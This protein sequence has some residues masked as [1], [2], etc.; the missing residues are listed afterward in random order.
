MRAYCQPSDL[1]PVELNVEAVHHRPAVIVV[2][3][4]GQA[5]GCRCPEYGVTSRRV[6]SNLLR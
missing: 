1:M 4:H 2:T 5:R 3:A 6:Q